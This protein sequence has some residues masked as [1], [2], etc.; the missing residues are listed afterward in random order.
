MVKMKE[1]LNTLPFENIAVHI[2]DQN[3]DDVGS[4]S[5]VFN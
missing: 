5:V 4:N 1:T 2:F 3:M